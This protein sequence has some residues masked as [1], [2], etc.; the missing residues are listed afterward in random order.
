MRVD[1]HGQAFYTADAINLDL[2]HAAQTA[3]GRREHALPLEYLGNFAKRPPAHDYGPHDPNSTRLPKTITI[4]ALVKG[5]GD[6]DRVMPFPAL[7]LEQVR[8]RND[9]AHRAARRYFHGR[10]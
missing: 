3:A 7:L 6:R 10:Y 1:K 2:V 9:T 5:E 4:G 8:R